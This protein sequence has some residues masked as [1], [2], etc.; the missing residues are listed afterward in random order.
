MRLGHGFGN[1]PA[2][3]PLSDSSMRSAAGIGAL[4]VVM[5]VALTPASARADKSVADLLGQPATAEGQPKTYL[6]ELTPT[7]HAQNTISFELYYSFF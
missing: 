2:T 6:E 4:L 3:R 7:S 5:L 1:R